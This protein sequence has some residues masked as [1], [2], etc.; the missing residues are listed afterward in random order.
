MDGFR[1]IK[2]FSLLIVY[3]PVLKRRF[4]MNGFILFLK[5][6]LNMMALFVLS[7]DVWEKNT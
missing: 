5:L 1:E 4:Q 7:R 6:D 2:F 3:F